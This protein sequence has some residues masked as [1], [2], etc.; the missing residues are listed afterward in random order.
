MRP[1]RQNLNVNFFTFRS[2]P[3]RSLGGRQAPIFENFP[4]R[5]IFLKFC[6]FKYKNERWRSQRPTLKRPVGRFHSLSPSRKLEICPL[7]EW[8]LPI[9]PYIKV[10]RP[11]AL[12]NCGGFAHLPFEGFGPKFNQSLNCTYVDFPFY[13]RPSNL[14]PSSL[15]LSRCLSLSRSCPTR[16]RSRRRPP[17]PQRRPQAAPCPPAQHAHDVPQAPVPGRRSTPPARRPPSRPA[18]RTGRQAASPG[19]FGRRRGGPRVST[20]R[21]SRWPHLVP[22]P[23]QPN[24]GG[25][26]GW[27]PWRRHGGARGQGRKTGPFGRRRGGG[28][29][30]PVGRRL[31]EGPQRAEAA[32]RATASGSG[33]RQAASPSSASRMARGSTT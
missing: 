26:G 8:A 5:H 30:G 18:R 6:F 23:M 13:P 12:L 14:I 16:A 32:G 7:Q 20:A 31:W 17:A 22:T 24:L 19:E 9:Y 2:S 4:I 25:H 15:H 33:N 1:R 3:Y 21:Q 29:R 10:L 11:F 28:G 27:R